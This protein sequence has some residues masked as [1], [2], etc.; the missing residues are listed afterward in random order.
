MIRDMAEERVVMLSTHVLEEVEA[1]CTRAII[2][3]EGKVVADD[4]PSQLKT[5]ST[6]YNAVTLRAEGKEVAETLGKLPAIGKVQSLD[7]GGVIAF[8]KAG[9]SI[10]AEILATAQSKNWKVS[11]IK[12]DEG[13]LDDVFHQITA[14]EDTSKKEVA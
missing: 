6:K 14:T 1:I 3:S 7:D 2:I 9:K 13:R 11:D 10:A 12:V 4:S 8:P 5:R